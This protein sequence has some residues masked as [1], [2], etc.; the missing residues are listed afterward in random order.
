MTL[1]K[2]SA[3]T[4]AIL[5]AIA[6]GVWIGPYVTDRND[7]VT[8]MASIETSPST[9]PARAEPSD[10]LRAPRTAKPNATPRVA[11]AASPVPIVLSAP[12]QRKKLQPVLNRGAD[13]SIA[14]SGF[15]N[16]EQF[17]TVAHAARNTNIPF[18]LLKHRVLNEGKTLAQAIH[19]SKP[20]LD[21]AAEVKAAQ[22]SAR[23]DLQAI[24]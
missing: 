14:S 6:F 20:E 11:T 21:A 2:A 22:T 9:V 15:R 19:E 1:G 4:V 17:A 23:R 13:L 12:E 5:A 24:G 18:V 16:A 8:P 10:K 7:E 3:L